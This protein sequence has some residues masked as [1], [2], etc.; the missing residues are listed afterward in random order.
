[1]NRATRRLYGAA[2][3]S[4]S[5][6]T[7]APV[8]RSQVIRRMHLGLETPDAHTAARRPRFL[9]LTTDPG[10]SFEI[11]AARIGQR[12]ETLRR[13]IARETGDRMEYLTVAERG[14]HGQRRLHLHTVY[15]GPYLPQARWSTLAERA[16]LGRIVDVRAVRSGELAS[17]AAKTLGSYLTKGAAEVWPRHFRRV[18]ASR[19][20]SPAWVVYKPAGTGDWIRLGMEPAFDAR[21]WI[22]DL[23]DR[24]RSTGQPA[25]PPG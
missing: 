12:F 21:A 1:M 8:K 20:W 14:S 16:G 6:G 19:G 9:T 7:C 13:S 15:R 22:G 4:W 3:G 25:A 17:Y 10:E 24:L 5:C 2:C 23:A 11:A 18:R